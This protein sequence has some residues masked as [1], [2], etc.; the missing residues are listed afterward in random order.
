MQ[1]AA[2]AAVKIELSSGTAASPSQV[3]KLALKPCGRDPRATFA[4]IYRCSICTCRVA[5]PTWGWQTWI[6]LNLLL[7]VVG[8]PVNI[9]CGRQVGKRPSLPF[10]PVGSDECAAWVYPDSSDVTVRWVYI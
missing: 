10:G 3:W 1:C 5:P 7:E 4:M 2:V 9:H 6:K 8:D